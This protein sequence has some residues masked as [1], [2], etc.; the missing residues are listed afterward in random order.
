MP[1]W[2]WLMFSLA[3]IGW[4]YHQFATLY[5]RSAAP[6]H[7]NPPAALAGQHLTI[8]ETVG[9]HLVPTATGVLLAHT[10]LTVKNQITLD[11]ATQRVSAMADSP[12]LPLYVGWDWDAVQA[13]VR[14]NQAQQ[15]PSH[16]GL[17]NPLLDDGSAGFDIPAFSI[18]TPSRLPL[19]A[20]DDPTGRL[21]IQYHDS[22]AITVLSDTH[23]IQNKRGQPS[24]SPVIFHREAWVLWSDTPDELHAGVQIRRIPTADRFGALQ[25]TLYAPASVPSARLRTTTRF[26][27]GQG[28]V[29]TLNLVPGTYTFPTRPA[30]LEDAALFDEAVANGLLTVAADQ[31][32][33]APYELIRRQRY[34]QRY[35]VRHPEWL[36]P[37]A[38]LQPWQALAWTDRHTQLLHALY[39]SPSGQYVHQQIERFNTHRLLAA[40]RIRLP[41]QTLSE[42]L[43]GFGQA[44]WQGLQLP[45]TP[46]M[47]LLAGR[48]FSELPQHWLPWQRIEKWPM[49]TD[50]TT[51]IHYRVTRTD[52]TESIP[53]ELMIVGHDI[54]VDNAVVMERTPRCLE[55]ACR[56]QPDALQLRVLWKKG[57]TE[58][59]IALRPH[60]SHALAD[61]YRY[62]FEHIQFHQG[63]LRWH[64]RPSTV[65]TALL[66]ERL[67]IILTD[68]Q[69]ETLLDALGP[70][71]AAYQHGL[72]PLVGV[73]PAQQTSVGGVLAQWAQS[74]PT[75]PLLS[76]R[77]SLDLTFQRKAQA[78]LFQRL[79]AIPP[80]TDRWRDRYASL[81]V[82]DATTGDILAAASNNTVLSH[83]AGWITQWSDLYSFDTANP[84]A[85]PLRWWA[86]QHDGSH[87]HV[88]GSAFK[89]IDALLF[90]QIAAT[91]PA[92]QA[93]LEGLDETGLI[94]HPLAVQYQFDP[95]SPCYPARAGRCTPAAERRRPAVHNYSVGGYETP[96]NR[97]QRFKEPR[98]GLEQA[99]R[100]SMNTWFAWL[101]ET[102]DQTLL[103]DPQAPG[104]PHV[105]ALTPHAL[106][107]VRPL[108]AVARQLGFTHAYRLDGGLL[109]TDW[110]SLGLLQTT[111]SHLDPFAARHDVRLAA[112]GF[113]MQVTP[114]HMAVIA[115]SIATERRVRPRLLLEL[116][117]RQADTPTFP[118]LGIATQR[119]RRGLKRV[120]EAG[121][122]AQT[123]FAEPRLTA[124]RPFLYA[125]TG[126]GDLAGDVGNTVWLVGW[127]EAGGIPNESRTLA[128][129][130]VISH[131]ERTGGA[132]C[133]PVVADFLASLQPSPPAL[134][135]PPKVPT[136][137]SRA[138]SPLATHPITAPPPARSW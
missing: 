3:S 78:A 96:A 117:G 79:Q 94:R 120:P 122:T 108:E 18:R 106:A 134:P 75:A 43:V 116:H 57:A 55:T 41:D 101:V 127:L 35:G 25:V 26:Y 126:T 92:F 128:F 109:P 9:F 14:H 97:L 20:D 32:R 86:W 27:D 80:D 29:E 133:G 67:P 59:V 30:R 34:A 10:G 19:T 114:L 91:Q 38:L 33:V 113:R 16:Y 22:K 68:R 84:R 112:L 51:Q 132:N 74:A 49:G 60:A 136:E 54:H 6:Q 118:P 72:A 83:P 37:S 8:P 103:D 123:A 88:A 105:R 15:R 129:A 31:L 110:Q 50:T 71:Q 93:L 11:L 1:K 125:K 12:L 46:T 102:T 24:A 99:L 89:L 28:T 98:Y 76:G 104:V 119:I 115:A 64:D 39:F 82:L 53:L 85:S 48:L 21:A 56:D 95:R 130:C 61:L 52:A 45:L 47:P 81:V 13:F 63:Q 58:L 69:G 4:V 121:G 124:L 66:E 2:V 107:A 131:I 62:D 36:L 7:I 5:A 42:T 65:K 138:P 100:D 23:L 135:V 73:H 70:T 90:E 111:P 40:V 87:V 137:L 44:D 77:L 17:K